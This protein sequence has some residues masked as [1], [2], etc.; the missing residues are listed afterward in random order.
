M[1]MANIKLVL[2]ICCLLLASVYLLGCGD[3]APV[4]SEKALPEAKTITDHSGRKVEIPAQVDRVVTGRILPFPATY[5]LA[6]GSCKELVG[7]HPASKSAAQHSVLKDM[8]PEIMQAQTSFLQGSDM[9]IEELLKL[10]P[11]LVFELGENNSQNIEKLEAAGLTTVAINTMSLHKGDSLKTMNSWL[12][13]LGQIT[14]KKE[15]ADEVIAYGN[16]TQAMIAERLKGVAEKDEPRGLMIFRLTE[17]E[18]EVS[19]SGFFGHYWLNYT[20]AQDVAEA[21]KVKALVDMEQIYAWNPDVIY[22]TNFSPA[23]PEDLINNTIP[24]QDWSKVKA[25][26]EGKVYK[27]PLGIY[28]WFPPSGDAPLMLKWLA[29]KH[30]PELF[31]DYKIEDEIKAYYKRFYQY[32]LSDQ[33]IN[34][35]LHPARE[36]SDGYKG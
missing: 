11:D 36:A 15:R 28:R 34:T 6:T 1:K 8:A 16:E 23:Q 5:Y 12:E 33:Q 30:H 24:G 27:I 9:N 26:K 13:L 17:K 14:G 29:Q 21:I 22:L 19:G 18:I 20:G 25:V 10:Q 7:I 35:I 31:A 3:K 32:E 2:G 4:S